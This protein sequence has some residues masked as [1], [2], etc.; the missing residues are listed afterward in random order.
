M[1]YFFT[2]QS[3]SKARPRLRGRL[4]YGRIPHSLLFAAILLVG[5]SLPLAAENDLAIGTA[6]GSFTYEGA[7]FDLKFAAAFVAYR[8]SDKPMI[9]LLSDTK[10]PSDRWL[11]EFN[12]MENKTPWS[13]VVFF[14]KKGEVFR[15]DVHVKGQQSSVSGELELKLNDPTAKELTGRASCRENNK[16]TKLDVTFHTNGIL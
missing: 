6:R 7:T 11:S 10:L 4:R 3:A 13:G 16:G 1:R 15:T 14:L 8:Q 12:I 9:I 5:T 2:P